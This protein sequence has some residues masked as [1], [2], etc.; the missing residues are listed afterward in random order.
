MWAYAFTAFYTISSPVPGIVGFITSIIHLFSPLLFLVSNNVILITLVMLISG[1]IHQ[2]TFSYY[3]GGYESHILIW[4]GIIPMLA[5]IIA[6]LKTLIITSITVFIISGAYFVLHLSGFEFPYLITKEG[7]I[8]AQ[9][10]LV[11]GWIIVS[12]SVVAYFLFLNKKIEDKLNQQKEKSDNLLQVLLHDISNQVQVIGVSSKLLNH[13]NTDCRF[14]NMGRE[15][16]SN[17]CKNVNSV[18]HS[19]RSIYIY[20]KQNRNIDLKP[21]SLLECINDATRSIEKMS[22]EKEVS[23]DL[24]SQDFIISSEPN[25]LIQ[26]VFVNLLSNS[27]KFSKRGKRIKINF[28]QLH[29][30]KVYISI[31]DQGIGIPKEILRNLF[32]SNTITTRL[33]TENEKGTGLG[34]L[35][36]KSIC[37]LLEGKLEVHT[38]TEE[39]RSGTQYNITLPLA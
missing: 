38:S 36:A 1:V 3:T 4:Y 7:W 18:I 5:G 33:G 14:I 37:E 23:F 10:L 12:T 27:V 19:V 16:I 22:R 11:F 35:I 6:G 30:N 21:I 8:I 15:N 39:D 34:M 32:N 29:E 2:G 26:Q 28:Q 9:S 17:G 24:P 31:S 25:L 20:E 13:V